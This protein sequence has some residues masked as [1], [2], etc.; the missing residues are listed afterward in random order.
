[1]SDTVGL[2]ALQ[3]SAY[4][5]EAIAHNDFT[6]LP[7]HQ[8]VEEMQA[9]F[10]YQIILKAERGDKI[11]GS[12]RGYDENGTCYIG[13]LI[14]DPR[15]QDQG[16]GTRLMKAIE[17]RF[18]DSE[19]YELFTGFKSAKNLYLYKKL[20]YEKFKEEQISSKLT[21]IILQKTRKTA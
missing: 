20:G 2:L 21:L 13:K 14:V 11:I 19:R 15:E 9:E 10:E 3:K 1:M 16:I 8:T 12:V 17:Q 4:L 18:G 6:I 7:L 5:S